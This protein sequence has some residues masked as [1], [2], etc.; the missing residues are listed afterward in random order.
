MLQTF[1]CKSNELNLYSH[2]FVHPNFDV[3]KFNIN[4]PHT[5]IEWQCAFFSSTEAKQADNLPLNSIS[6]VNLHSR[7]FTEYL[8]K[9]KAKGLLL[10]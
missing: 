10:T 8:K 6:R 4:Q 1:N 3:S 5:L 9:K 2:H 7:A